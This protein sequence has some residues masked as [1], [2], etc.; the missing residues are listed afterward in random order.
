MNL[1]Y[2][3]KVPILACLS[4]PP[5]PASS[6]PPVSGQAELAHTQRAVHPRNVA[7]LAQR[8]GKQSQL[9]QSSDWAS[10]P[11]RACRECV[12]VALI[13]LLDR[14]RDL[15]SASEDNL[16]RAAIEALIAA[17]LRRS[18]VGPACSP[19]WTG[20]SCSGWPLTTCPIV[21]LEDRAQVEACRILLR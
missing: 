14:S 20:G 21:A 19:R 10:A 9:N 6:V 3:R 13:L 7:K 8:L 1:P 15:T 18:F 11:R 2:I 4:C 17:G 12:D 5:P 16:T